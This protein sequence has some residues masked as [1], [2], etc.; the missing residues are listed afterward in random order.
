[1]VGSRKRVTFFFGIGSRYSYIAATQIPRFQAETGAVIEWCPIVSSCLVASKDHA[2]FRW[3]DDAKDWWGARVSGQYKESYRQTDLARWARFYNIVYN[4]PKKPLMSA[5]RRTLYAVAATMLGVG[6]R[7]NLALLEQIYG[8]GVAISEK[9]CKS[10]ARSA[11]INLRELEDLLD[12]D[13]VQ[14]KH[15]S[16]VKT[17]KKA[18]IFG[19]PTFTLDQE[20]YWGVDRLPLLES[21][22][23][24]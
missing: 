19:V 23:R 24:S 10:L 1:M 13:A 5:K 12:S 16:W 17:A 15:D 4:E 18:G 14:A 11:G 2:P 7:Y 20:F 21:A 22:L 9:D 8:R 6:E 3:N